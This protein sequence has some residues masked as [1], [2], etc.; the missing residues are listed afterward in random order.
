MDEDYSNKIP[1]EFCHHQINFDEYATHVDQCQQQLN[2]PNAMFQ[3]LFQN[4][5]GNMQVENEESDDDLL[6]EEENQEPVQLPVS[7]FSN[8]MEQIQQISNSPV[9]HSNRES[10]VEN[11]QLPSPHDDNWDTDITEI[12]IENSKKEFQTFQELSDFLEREGFANVPDPYPNG[13]PYNI[14]FCF[15]L[16][17]YKIGHISAV[18]DQQQPDFQILLGGLGA[19]PAGFDFS[20]IFGN[21]SNLTNLINNPEGQGE[22]SGNMYNYWTDL[23]ANAGVVEIGVTNI[24]KVAPMVSLSELDKMENLE[25]CSICQDDIASDCRKTICKHYYCSACIEP[26]LEKHKTCPVCLTDLE[27]KLAENES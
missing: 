24:D 16:D 11:S 8:L 5:G 23:T 19:Q 4:L 14:K 18:I 1:C 10:S 21:I 13:A 6:D 22:G 2:Q 12:D 20:Q 3:Q 9:T 15:K 26:W 17:S 27:D 7:I 25:K